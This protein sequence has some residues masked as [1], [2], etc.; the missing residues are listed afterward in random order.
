MEP[1]DTPAD[2]LGPRERLKEALDEIFTEKINSKH[3]LD[4]IEGKLFD[5]GAESYTVGSHE[6]DPAD[7]EDD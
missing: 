7:D 6:F 5:I 2:R 4:S 3:H 1:E